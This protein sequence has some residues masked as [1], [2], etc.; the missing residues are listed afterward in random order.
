LLFFQCGTLSLIML[1]A[2]L[3]GLARQFAATYA[4]SK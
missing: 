3:F 4:L 1:P 2:L